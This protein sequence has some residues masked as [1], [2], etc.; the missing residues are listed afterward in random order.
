[1]LGILCKAF[2]V[3]PEIETSIL[4]TKKHITFHVIS[5]NLVINQNNTILVEFGYGNWLIVLLGTLRKHIK[6]ASSCHGYVDSNASLQNTN[7]ELDQT[8]MIGRQSVLKRPGGITPL[9]GLLTSSFSMAAD[10]W[11][12]HSKAWHLSRDVIS[13][14]FCKD[15]H[16]FKKRN[17]NVAL[18]TAKESNVKMRQWVETSLVL[19]SKI[20]L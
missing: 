20:T 5:E 6:L 2:H 16:V 8:S 19:L 3:S 17:K 7:R 4:F 11:Y 10:A 18:Q 1:M 12:S 13:P 14:S 15:S 9:H